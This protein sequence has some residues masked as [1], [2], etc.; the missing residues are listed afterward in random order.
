MAEFPD[1]LPA[2][3]L[4]LATDA[5][6]SAL[7]TTAPSAARVYVGDLPGPEGMPRRAVVVSA[8][9]GPPSMDF[10]RLGRVNFDVRAYGESGYHARRVHFA[11]L[12]ALKHLE[13]VV[14]TVPGIGAILLHT[15]VPLT[16][17]LEL[18]DPDTSW[19]FAFSSYRVLASESLAA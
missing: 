17:P 8:A 2:V 18:R 12:E 15:I 16:G 10:V 4:Y 1:P 13:R 5:A 6:V 19:P 11:V 3:R 14:V 9:G 7:V